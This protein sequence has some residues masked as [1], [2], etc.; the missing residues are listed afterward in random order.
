[1]DKKQ[2]TIYFDTFYE[3]IKP[4]Q[5]LRTQIWFFM[6]FRSRS[7]FSLENYCPFASNKNELIIYLQTI[8]S[9]K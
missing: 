1:M 5:L 9:E 3:I 6:I 4:G 8:V 2:V 7:F